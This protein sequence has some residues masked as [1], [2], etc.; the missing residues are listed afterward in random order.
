MPDSFPSFEK[1][2]LRERALE[3]VK[4]RGFEDLEAHRAYDEWIDEQEALATD[5]EN[6]DLAGLLLNIERA[7]F[8]RDAGYPAWARDGYTDAIE[9]ARQQGRM[10]LVAELIEER[11]QLL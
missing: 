3:L 10:D 4:E 1:N 6:T 8:D 9:H 7:R 5:A 11:R 2:P